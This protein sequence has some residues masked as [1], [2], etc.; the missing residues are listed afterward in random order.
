MFSDKIFATM[1]HRYHPPAFGCN[2][3]K[4]VNQSATKCVEQYY[5][6]N[7]TLLYYRIKLAAKRK[8]VVN[9]AI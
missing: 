2:Q 8:A 1:R 4:V 7:R 9:L 3:A 5:N 6:C